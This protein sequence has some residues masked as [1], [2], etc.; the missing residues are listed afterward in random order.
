VNTMQGPR[1]CLARSET[2]PHGSKFEFEVSSLAKRFGKDDGSVDAQELV[3]EWLD[4]SKL[5]GFGQWRN[6]GKGRAVCVVE[7]VS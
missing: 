5:R 2:V 4:Y 6:S 1:V 3:R 7:E